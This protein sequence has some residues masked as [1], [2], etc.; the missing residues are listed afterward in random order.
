MTI[1]SVGEHKAT[2]EVEL[3]NGTVVR[4]VVRFSSGNPSFHA[5]SAFE[6]ITVAEQAVTDGI[7]GIYG[8]RTVR[9]EA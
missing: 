7:I 8:P 9:L 4:H 5:S 3:G 6:A 1:S 2:V